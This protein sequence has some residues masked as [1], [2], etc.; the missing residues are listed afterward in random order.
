M[1]DEGARGA[2]Q[3]TCA[4]FVQLRTR[5]DQTAVATGML[6]YREDLWNATAAPDPAEII[7]G[8]VSWRGWERSLR[9]LISWSIFIAM[10]ILMLPIIAIIQ[11]IVNLEGYAKQDGTV[12]DIA[13][14]ILDLPVVAR[15]LPPTSPHAWLNPTAPCMCCMLPG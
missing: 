12:G 13:Q 5:R 2:V 1:R 14:G 10:L 6:S 4:A 3:E 15:V 11:Q 7:W 8:S 9:S